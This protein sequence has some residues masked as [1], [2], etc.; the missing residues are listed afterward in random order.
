MTCLTATAERLTNT[1]DEWTSFHKEHWDELALNKSVVP[2]RPDYA[3]YKAL[4]AAGMIVF[5][6]LR[7]DEKMVG[8]FVGFLFPCIHYQILTCTMD[9]FFVHP[10]FRGRHGGVRMFRA[11]KRELERLGVK[12]WFVGEKLHKPSGRLF[13]A[14]G[15][16][17]IETHYSMMIGT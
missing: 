15:F 12:R 8:Y 11:V 6:A 13:K 7:Q 14:L 4:D 10:A 17:P 1:F 16:S 2:L 3:K 9:I 5:V